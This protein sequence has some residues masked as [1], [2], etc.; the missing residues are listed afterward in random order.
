M[1]CVARGKHLKFRFCFFSAMAD[2]KNP[3]GFAYFRSGSGSG[4]GSG[5][6]SPEE[7]FLFYVRKFFSRFLRAAFILRMTSFHNW[8]PILGTILLEVSI[9]R[10]SGAVKPKVGVHAHPARYKNKAPRQ[11]RRRQVRHATPSTTTST[12]SKPDRR[13][14]TTSTQSTTDCSQRRTMA[15]A[16]G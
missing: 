1:Q 14:V 5:D 4:F 3:R 13:P 8:N 11:H 12:Q 7:V 2:K 6:K 16:A 9:G 10:D 15:E